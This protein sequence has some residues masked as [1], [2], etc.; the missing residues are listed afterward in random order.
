MSTRTV[1]LETAP[2]RDPGT[3]M[4]VIRVTINLPG[5]STRLDIRKGA[6][7]VRTVRL[8]SKLLDC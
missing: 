6:H 2:A 5:K 3:R 4:V 1:G 7:A 8:Q